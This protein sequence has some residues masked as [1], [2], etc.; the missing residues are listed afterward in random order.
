M[1]HTTN[2]VNSVKIDRENLPYLLLTSMSFIVLF[3]QAHTKCLKLWEPLRLVPKQKESSSKGP[4]A[5]SN[6]NTQGKDRQGVHLG[7]VQPNVLADPIL[8]HSFS[9]SYTKQFE[10]VRNMNFFRVASDSGTNALGPLNFYQRV[11]ITWIFTFVNTK[12]LMLYA[13][14]YGYL[15]C[16][17]FHF[18]CDASFCLVFICCWHFKYLIWHR[19]NS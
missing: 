10:Q 15:L 18:S 1:P 14:T 7:L 19:N 13:Y 5:S 12:T 6:K 11:K 9:D 8:D 16:L 17:A 4:L 3:I 2:P